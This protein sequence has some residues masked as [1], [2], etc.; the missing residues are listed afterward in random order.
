MY[1]Y[2]IE[3]VNSQTIIYIAI[4]N[5]T[6]WTELFYLGGGTVGSLP[7]TTLGSV[8]KC[9]KESDLIVTQP[10]NLFS[11]KCYMINLLLHVIC[12]LFFYKIN[13]LKK[14]FFLG[15]KKPSISCH[16]NPLSIPW[17]I[18]SKEDQP[19]ATFRTFPYVMFLSEPP[20][21]F[22]DFLCFADEL[23]LSFFTLQRL[24]RKV[25][26]CYLYKLNCSVYFIK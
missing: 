22:L 8:M 11:D 17:N 4:G 24:R 10:S 1:S 12:K 15:K 5:H 20:S 9:L 23:I 16:G 21:V 6:V 25:L 18:L 2:H 3:D 13:L 19:I 7:Y 14:T 26:W